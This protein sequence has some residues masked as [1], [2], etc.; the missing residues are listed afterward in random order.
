MF[1]RANAHKLALTKFPF[2][3]KINFSVHSAEHVSD[4]SVSRALDQGLRGKRFKSRSGYY[5]I[6]LPS[7]NA[8]VLNANIIIFL[9]GQY[10]NLA[11]LDL[12]IRLK[13]S[14]Y[15]YPLHESLYI[16]HIHNSFYLITNTC[17]NTKQVYCAFYMW[18]NSM[19]IHLIICIH[20]NKKITFCS[21]L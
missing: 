16:Y 9:C 2:T 11:N 3:S 21:H 17:V 18:T 20:S 5:K 15:Q 19:A 14:C 4:C 1:N 12:D 13:K 6:F 8:G 10:A 7:Y